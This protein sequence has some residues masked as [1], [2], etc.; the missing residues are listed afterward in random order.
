MGNSAKRKNGNIRGAKWDWV[1]IENLILSG[2]SNR[3]ILEMP[4]FEGMSYD[5]LKNRAAKFG[6]HRK[7][8]EIKLIASGG[9]NRNIAEQR[10]EGIE[11]HHVFTFQQL[12][13]MRGAIL[14]HKVKGTVK[15]LREMMGLFQS[16]I[17]AAEQSYGLKGQD[18]DQRAISLNAM[19]SLHVR[20]P[21]KDETPVVTGNIIVEEVRDMT[22]TI[23][24]GAEIGGSDPDSGAEG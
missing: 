20:P 17:D 11:K 19:V 8:E 7:K 13:K 2:K 23:E 16:Y 10:T 24:A 21:Q 3:E 22:G 1:K 14:E 5:Y 6:L 4:E 12:E 15:D 18:M 9:V